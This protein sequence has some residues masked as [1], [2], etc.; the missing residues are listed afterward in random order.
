MCIRVHGKAQRKKNIQY[1]NKLQSFLCGCNGLMFVFIIF[2][3]S[4]VLV[5][6]KIA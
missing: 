5:P 4:V 3:I 1:L 2:V 6:F